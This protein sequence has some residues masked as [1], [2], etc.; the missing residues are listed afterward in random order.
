MGLH[1][2]FDRTFYVI[3]GATKTSGGSL[4]LVKGQFALVDGAETSADG[5][6]ILGSLAGVRKRHKFL[7]LRVGGDGK[8]LCLSHLKT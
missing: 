8:T 6:K 3:G 7:E 2:P 1:K 4:N 5:A